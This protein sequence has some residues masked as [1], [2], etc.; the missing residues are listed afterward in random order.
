M[1]RIYL[2][3][4]MLLFSAIFVGAQN[5]VLKGVITD[6]N[7]QQPLPGANVYFSG[8]SEG[9]ATNN[10]GRYQI[11]KLEPGNY[12]LIISF[13][14][15]KKVKQN[16]TIKEGENNLNVELE[17]SNS[18]LG[19]VVVTGTGTPHHLK[20]APVPIE[21]ISQKAVVSTG[22][23]D[24][25]ELMMNITP[26]FDFNSGTM[27]S[28]MTINGLGNDFIL[29]LVDGKRMYGD[30]GGQTNLSRINPDNIERIEIVKG[31]SSLLYGSDAI[32]GVV[33]VI[34]KKSKQKVNIS[35]TTR[36]RDYATFQQSN[37]INLNL[38]KFSWNGNFNQNSSDGWQLSP[39]EFVKGE[40]VKT[41]ALV[42]NKYKNYTLSHLLSFRATDKLEIY[43]GNSIY[44]SDVF[45]PVSVK[46]YGF[47]YN[48]KIYQ[49]GVKYLLKDGDYIS[50]DYNYDQFLY[51]FKYNQDDNGFANGQNV[52]NNDQ[53]MNS[54]RLKYVNK[55]SKNNTLSLGSDYLQEK[56]VSAER[57]VDG[58][59][60]AS[61][62]AFYGQDEITLFK[63]LN[64]VTGVRFVKHTEFGTAVTPKV[65]LLYKLNNINLRGTYGYGF[66]APTLKELYYV[67]EKRG[68]LYLGN[69]E[70]DP[71]TSQFY[72]AGIEFNN[73]IISSSITGY[74]NN[75]YDMIDY[76]TIDLQPDDADN[77][78]KKRRRHYNIE[79]ARSQGIDVLINV[80]VGYGFTVGGGYSFVD[81]KDVTKKVRLERVAKNY[82][83]MSMAY[84]HSW[85]W[86][87]LNANILGR[88][89][90]EKFFDDGNAKA[91]DIW[92]LTTNHKFTN[93]GAFILEASAGIDNIFDFIDDSPYGSHYATINAG[94]T[95]FLGLKINFAQ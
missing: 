91:Y 78:I 70:L 20:A 51:Y 29:V 49:A 92:K 37:A 80:K 55:L 22:A 75:V 53:R 26:S 82:G 64:I 34:T 13:S 95:F 9:T 63:N 67:Y 65:S 12:D 39:Y 17:E 61:T 56:M 18:S 44:E 77:G 31:A 86:Y 32:A 87:H 47:Y 48:D 41:D 66:K 50:L 35:S 1:Q 93:L 16:V 73:H 40:L 8:S 69:T 19:E 7:N 24:F 62:V 88:I 79:E 10:R 33:N 14:G 6:K 5:A 71:Q 60:E 59:A 85:K 38:G 2:V 4:V 81:A 84:D 57:L 72:S 76:Q 68:T 52:I 25:S 83:N 23:S 58:E 30:V 42:Q 21:L 28:F 3:A 90:D 43:A 74:V 15:F 45:F 36:I 54:V 46:N 11:K 89:Q 27:G 94:R